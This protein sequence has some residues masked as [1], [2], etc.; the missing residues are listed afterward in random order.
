M[1]TQARSVGHAEAVV[2]LW[3]LGTLLQTYLGSQ[4]V[5]GPAEVQAVAAQWTTTGRLS[6]WAH[7][8]CALRDPLLRAW[9]GPALQAGAAR[10]A[11][12][13]HAPAPPQR[14]PPD[15]AAPQQVAA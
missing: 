3:A 4:V 2:G 12:A 15:H 5:Q 8:Q 14:R 11:P 1:L 10:V 13:S 7:G 9:I 6:V